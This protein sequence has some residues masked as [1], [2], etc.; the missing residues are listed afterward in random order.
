VRKLTVPAHVSNE[1]D[2]PLIDDGE[3]RRA[4]LSER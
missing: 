2:A 1:E 3:L 4:D